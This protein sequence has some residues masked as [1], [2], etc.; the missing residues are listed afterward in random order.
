MQLTLEIFR[1]VQAGD[2]F[3][4]RGGTQEY[5]LRTPLGGAETATLDWDEQLLFDLAAV[6]LPG[7]DP[8]VVQRVGERL[9]RFL[10]GTSFALRESELQAA[11]ER[12]E[13][14]Q[15]TLRFAAAEL[16]AL[17]WELLTL[18]ESGQFIGALPGVLLRYTWPETTSAKEHPAPPRE[19]GRLLF[20]WSAADGAVPAAEQLAAIERACLR[21]HHPFD[22]RRDVLQHVSYARLDAALREADVDRPIAVLHLLCHGAHRDSTFGLAWNGDGDSSVTDIIDGTRLRQ[23]LAPH[24]GSLRLVVLSAC[25]GGNSG[26]LGN[27]LGSLAQVL[28]RAGIAAVVASRFPLSASGSVHITSV[29]Y[30]EL[31]S[32]LSSLE[33]AFIAV[34]QRLLS[35]ASQLDWASLQLY[36]RLED[37][38][39]SRPFTVRPYRG[40]EPF[41]ASHSR[42][43]FGRERERQQAQDTLF[44]LRRDGKPRFLVVAGASGTGKSSVVLGG[45]V[46]DLTMAQIGELRTSD[47]RRAFTEFIA[48]LDPRSQSATLR[49]AIAAIDQALT[50]L[51]DGGPWEWTMMRPGTDPIAALELSLRN[52]RDPNLPFLLCVDQFEEI[53]THAAANVRESFARRLWALAKEPT[54]VHVVITLRV[55]F[56][57]HC[58]ELVLDENG[59][60]LDRIAYSETHRVFVAQLEPAQLHAAIRGPAR[61]VGLELPPALV[62]QM[63]GEVEGE[64]GALPLLEYVLDRLWQERQ[65]RN[66]S[67]QVY[68][69]LGGVTGALGRNADQVLAGLGEHDQRLARQLLI[70]LVHLSDKQGA[71]TR[72][73]VPLSRLR[74]QIRDV[75]GR[76]DLVL[77][78]FVDARLLVRSEEAGQPTI[79]VAHE[80]LIRKWPRLSAW[81]VEDRQRLIELHEL[82][83]WAEQYAN[84]RTL[85]RGTQLGYAMRILRK[86]PDELGV[87]IPRMIRDSMAAQRRQRVLVSTA[88]IVALAA[89]SGLSLLARMQKQQA[90]AER[91]VAV[92]KERIAASRLLGMR[93]ERVLAAEPDLGLLL[94]ARAY[95][96]HRELSSRSVL[97]AAL[98]RTRSVARFL[99][100]PRGRVPSV[101]FSPDGSQLAAIGDGGE[102]HIFDTRSGARTAH[103]VTTEKSPLHATMWSP[104]GLHLAASNG[105]RVYLWDATHF[106]RPAESL[107]ATA[108]T[109]YS[110]AWSSSSE[111]LAAGSEDGRI[112]LWDA[113]KRR[114]LAPIVPGQ[115]QIISSIKFLADS[116]GNGRR[117]TRLLVGG[118]TGSVSLFEVA[119]RQRLLGPLPTDRGVVSSVASSPDG[120]LLAAASEDRAVFLWD[121]ET[122]KPH[123]E[124][125]IRHENAVSCVRFS[126]DGKLLA[127]FGIDRTIQLWDVRS[128]KPIDAPL[129]VHATPIYSC[130]YG[131]GDQLASGSDDLVLLWN[132]ADHPAVRRTQQPAEVSALAIDPSR[133][134][135]LIGGTDGAL[136]LWN[137]DDP[138][139]AP[140]PT[141]VAAP[142]INSVI[143]SSSGDRAIS[144][145]NAGTVRI[146]DGKTLTERQ[147]LVSVEHGSVMA[148]ALSPSPRD[149]LLAAGY[150]DGTIAL[151][152]LATGKLN[153][154]AVVTR[155]Q[156]ITALAWLPDGDA[157]VSGGLD[158]TIRLWQR[159]NLTPRC[160]TQSSHSAGEPPHS[161]AVSSLSLHPNKTL[162]ASSG[163]DRRILL[164]QLPE[165]SATAQRCPTALAE[166]PQAHP[167][168]VT[169]LQFRDDGTTLASGGEDGA[170]VLWDV[171]TRQPIGRPMRGHLLPVMALGFGKNGRLVSADEE[172]VQRWDTDDSHWLPSACARAN[173]NL[174]LA[175]WQRFLGE[176]PYCR[177]CPTL[178]AGSD[179]PPNAPSCR[180]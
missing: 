35:E 166:L 143:W 119:T 76:L 6:R 135:A 128:G 17:P 69:S 19:A 77:A 118:S 111:L 45:L 37:G 121:A 113:E 167:A 38:S 73:R 142:V 1:S 108:R 39:D 56:L 5:V 85:L 60:R 86:Y 30:D 98:E 160:S 141:A 70:R 129:S 13:P 48:L 28:H 61:L 67:E 155:Q 63:V 68:A 29:I 174:T 64:P 163:R 168:G 3:A 78:A 151:W 12:Q 31:L 2:P 36:A 53:F 80:A 18:R 139:P 157:L 105:S 11:V 55:D 130:A 177:T 115:T 8:A 75:E 65:G 91:E 147:R 84:F 131:R 59:L 154:P 127:S 164:W 122:G 114:A 159:E 117:M 171:E 10:F 44:A 52:R 23:L 4:F 7:R 126:S 120:K 148:V 180:D 172:V 156:S 109:L 49:S 32:R 54:G 51:P 116:D 170:I 90:Q 20:A 83:K 140:G 34:R 176:R 145:D 103:L 136:R 42:F 107:S 66:L 16:F 150:A 146:L 47:A 158:G 89:L 132:L 82:E 152:N 87:L 21:G 94:A 41:L 43:M 14:V 162:L 175:E 74:E 72:R 79:E 101:G 165:K 24:A 57:G 104:D 102:L 149:D 15:L 40:L 178:A 144:A 153:T 137:L 96:M 123:G 124:P 112:L 33:N 97:H 92:K 110:I 173:R 133:Q 99:R 179:A 100:G 9:R 22:A 95:S 161:D 71:E 62:S 106:E 46:P 26:E 134:R 58:G 93:A 125:L 88:I 138:V 25:D 169:A 81:L 50:A 27:Q